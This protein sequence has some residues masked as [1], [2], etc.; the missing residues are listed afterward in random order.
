MGANCPRLSVGVA[1][2]KADLTNIAAA[3][4]LRIQNDP[5]VALV[6]N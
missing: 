6:Q 5:L 1:G 2:V 3:D 4:A